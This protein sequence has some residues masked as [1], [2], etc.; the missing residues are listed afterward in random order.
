MMNETMIDYRKLSID[1]RTIRD[2]VLKD[3]FEYKITTVPSLLI[4]HPNGN[5]DIYRGMEAF[6]YIEKHIVPVDKPVIDKV[7]QSSSTPQYTQLVIPQIPDIPE[8]PETPETPEIPEIPDEEIP[9]VQQIKR[10]DQN[11]LSIAQQM[12]KQREAEDQMR[13]QQLNLQERQPQRPI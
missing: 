12:E 8:I 9:S 6:D 10:K 11:L 7:E 5:M 3:E 13:N 4:F 2:K 1:N